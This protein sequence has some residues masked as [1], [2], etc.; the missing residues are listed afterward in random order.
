MLLGWVVLLLAAVAAVAAV[1]TGGGDAGGLWVAAK[2]SPSSSTP[3][4]RARWGFARPSHD[5]A[6]C[7]WEWSAGGCVPSNA[8]TATCRLRLLGESV[9]EPAS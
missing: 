6:A 8:R 5:A 7:H 2:A 9:C 3:A 1:I 4:A